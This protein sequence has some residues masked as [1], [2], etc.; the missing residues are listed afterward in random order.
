ML[1]CVWRKTST[2]QNVDI[3]MPWDWFL[4][5]NK[6]H[7]KCRIDACSY[8]LVVMRMSFTVTNALVGQ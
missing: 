5:A 1:G 2:T 8:F 3:V 7:P 4:E 6:H